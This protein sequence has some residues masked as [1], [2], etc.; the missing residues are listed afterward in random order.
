MAQLTHQLRE[1]TCPDGNPATI[2]V[3]N[4]S[5]DPASI[6]DFDSIFDE[7][8]S[9]G[10]KR[11]I[12][13]LEKL[14]YINSTGMGIMVQYCDQL[15]EDGGGLVL[16]RVQPKITLVLE[17]LGLQE[18]FPIVA[19][20]EEAVSALM[21][22]KVGPANVQVQLS[23]NEPQSTSPDTGMFSC[24]N[25][26]ADLII[27]G[28]GSYVCPRCRALITVDSQGRSETQAMTVGNANLELNIPIEV[29]YYK[30]AAALVARIGLKAGL[31]DADARAVAEA[32]LSALKILFD[33]CYG[34]GYSPDNPSQFNIMACADKGS[35]RVHI[36]T[37]GG[38][39]MDTDVFAPCGAGFDKVDYEA[40]NGGNLLTLEKQVS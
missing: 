8:L 1:I 27:P 35:F 6:D 18:F 24:G 17:M 13:D 25:C 5:I 4:G 31:S 9:A 26:T 38:R 21:G 20:E 16:M 36:Y 23:E 3:L 12:M 14:K 22:E 32:F 40:V 10:T 19:A 2:V 39:V 33:A 28:P 34:A 7:L 15:A 30:S 11:I 29:P 37:G